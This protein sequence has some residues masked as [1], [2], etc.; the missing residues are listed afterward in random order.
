MIIENAFGNWE[1]DCLVFYAVTRK[2]T[3]G[4]VMVISNILQWIG[5]LKMGLSL[6]I[7]HHFLDAWLLIG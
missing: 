3:L 1:I 5:G 4:R 2:T 6:E 7:H